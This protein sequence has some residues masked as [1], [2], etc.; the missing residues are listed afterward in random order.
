MIHALGQQLRKLSV[1]EYLE[2]TTGGYLAHG[3]R[4][5]PVMV[6]AITTLHEYRRI[7]QAFGIDLAAYIIK[8]YALPYVTS[9]V[10]YGRISIDIAKLSE[11]ES[12]AVVG[13][14][15]EAVHYY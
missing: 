1:V 4:V 9:C 13:G 10:L 12:V 8:M 14:V 11:A 5:E 6:I 15:C 3:R 2:G 7:R